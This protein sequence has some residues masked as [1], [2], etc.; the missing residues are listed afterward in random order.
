MLRIIQR[1]RDG[2]ELGNRFLL[3]NLSQMMSEV[4][5]ETGKKKLF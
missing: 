3:K 1:E 2:E 4:D 5:K